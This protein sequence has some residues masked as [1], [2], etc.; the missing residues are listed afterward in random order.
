ME[1]EEEEEEVEFVVGVVVYFCCV[2]EGVVEVGGEFGVGVVGVL[3]WEVEEGEE[4][5]GV[6]FDFIEKGVEGFVVEVGVGG[7]VWGGGMVE[8]FDFGEDV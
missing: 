2:V 7:V 6:G 4:V 3:G 5:R 1:V 8:F